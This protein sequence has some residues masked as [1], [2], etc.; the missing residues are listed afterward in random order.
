NCQHAPGIGVD[1]SL[2]YLEINLSFHVPKTIDQGFQFAERFAAFGAPAV[3]RQCGDRCN[4]PQQLT[5]CIIGG[6]DKDCLPPQH[7]RYADLL[8][9]LGIAFLLQEIA[10][11]GDA[12]QP[13]EIIAPRQFYGMADMFTVKSDTSVGSL[14]SIFPLEDE[15]MF[16]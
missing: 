5:R 10:P 11:L 6:M 14:C 1:L 9:V 13:L 4:T 12:A 16:F 8:T 15:G 7:R 2:F 3:A